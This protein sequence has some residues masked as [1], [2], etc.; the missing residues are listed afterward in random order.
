MK[1]RVKDPDP[2]TKAFIQERRAAAARVKELD[3]EAEAV[4]RDIYRGRAPD[5]E[6]ADHLHR[7]IAAKRELQ[8]EIKARIRWLDLAIEAG[9]MKARR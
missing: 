2:N 6:T 7:Q 8:A 3:R 9:V 1:N 5:A 4:Q